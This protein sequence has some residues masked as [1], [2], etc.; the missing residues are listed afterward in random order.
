MPLI[1]CRCYLTN[2]VISLPYY[3][4]INVELSRTGTYWLRKYNVNSSVTSSC[5]CRRMTSFHASRALMLYLA[6]FMC[7]RIN[8]NTER[9]SINKKNNSTNINNKHQQ[10]QQLP[11]SNSN[12]N[13][14]NN[15]DIINISVSKTM[16]MI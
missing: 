13:N 2:D 9:T 12:N 11:S 7:F 8:E 16:S 6:C 15:I 14:N 4:Q 1:G 10:Q 3:C 5:L